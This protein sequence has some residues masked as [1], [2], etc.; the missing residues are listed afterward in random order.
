[1]FHE[2]TVRCGRCGKRHRFRDVQADK[3]CTRCGWRNL[4]AVKREYVCDLDCREYPHR[5]GSAGCK[6][7]QDGKL[8]PAFELPP[9]YDDFPF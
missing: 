2:P 1:M 7:D 9:I 3:K 5:A 8:A 6:R 4:Y